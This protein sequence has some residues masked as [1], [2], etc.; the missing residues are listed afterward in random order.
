VAI[1]TL[2]IYSGVD[3]G[4]GQ[5][6]SYEGWIRRYKL[7]GDPF[8]YLFE[9]DSAGE[10]ERVGFAALLDMGTGDPNDNHSNN[11]W[12]SFLSFDLTGVDVSLVQEVRLGL[13][14]HELGTIIYDPP[15]QTPALSIRYGYDKFTSMDFLTFGRAGTRWPSSTGYWEPDWNDWAGAPTGAYKV[16]TASD[17]TPVTNFVGTLLQLRLQIATFP[18]GIGQYTT[19]RQRSADKWSPY[20]E[21]DLLADDLP[22]KEKI[23]GRADAGPLPGKA[24]LGGVEGR[25]HL[26]LPATAGVGQIMAKR[27]AGS[28]PGR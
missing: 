8:V 13:W 9:I 3:R 27:D 26:G 5:D 20:L 4:S 19:L 21:L 25:A 12:R 14:L 2:K 7:V 22:G 1:D 11:N 18:P 15:V 10:E 23:P 16:F 24:H 28:V 6:S 17:M